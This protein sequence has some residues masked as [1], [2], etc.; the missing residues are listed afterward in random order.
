MSGQQHRQAAGDERDRPRPVR[1]R[2]R[3]RGDLERLVLLGVREAVQTLGDLAQRGGVGLD[4]LVEPRRARHRLHLLAEEPIESVVVGDDLGPPVRLLV[5][6]IEPFLRS[7]QRAWKS[8]SAPLDLAQ[9]G[10]IL[11]AAVGVHQPALVRQRRAGLLCRDLD[12]AL[13]ERRLVGVDRDVIA[14]HGHADRHHQEHDQR[15]DHGHQ[16]AH[17]VVEP[18]RA[19]FTNQVPFLGVLSAI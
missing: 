14:P 10:R 5:R 15:A 18:L 1:L 16:P 9:V 19:S 13:R 6:V 3:G 7:G 2:A 17:R 4:A 11:V 8:L 12:L